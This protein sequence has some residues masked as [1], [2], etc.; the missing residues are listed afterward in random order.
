[1]TYQWERCNANGRLCTPIAGATAATYAVTAG[2]S[3]HTLLVAVTATLDTTQQVALS[4]HTG[5]VS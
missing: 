1:V 4:V 2:D 5:V 3:T